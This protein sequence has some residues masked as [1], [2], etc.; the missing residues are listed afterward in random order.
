M[1]QTSRWNI[2]KWVSFYKTYGE[3]GLLPRINQTYSA[4]F[5][6]KVLKSIEKE[7]LPLMQANLRFNI[8]DISIFL[9]WKKDFANFGL[10]ELQPK[11][12]GRPAMSDKG[13]KR[14]SDKPRLA[15][16]NET[17][18]RFIKTKRNQTKHVKKR[19][20]LR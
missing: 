5:K 10:V 20:L 7:S 6:L 16:S 2:R 18:P 8:P 11:Q 3:I 19:K 1:K 12:R 13:R 4:K 14:K 17:L 15:I 9:K